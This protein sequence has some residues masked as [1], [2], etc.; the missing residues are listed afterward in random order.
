MGE[1]QERDEE[2]FM[3]AEGYTMLLGLGKD[4]K[5]TIVRRSDGFERRLLYRCFRCGLVVGYEILQDGNLISVDGRGGFKGKVIYILPAGVVSTQR[6]MSG[7]GGFR[8]VEGVGMGIEG[9]GEG[10]VVGVW[11]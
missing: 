3:P 2:A 11:E 10:V 4:Q 8:T 7:E 6:M 1:E 9:K 5:P